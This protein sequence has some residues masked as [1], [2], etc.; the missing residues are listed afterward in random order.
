MPPDEPLS[1]LPVPAPRA[2]RSLTARLRDLI[3]LVPRPVA[4]SLYV[5]GENLPENVPAR[6]LIAQ[7][8]DDWPTDRP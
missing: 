1:L 8:L 2:D 3:S 6:R 4:A 7:I 5:D